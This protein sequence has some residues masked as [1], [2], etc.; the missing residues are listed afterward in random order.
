MQCE[1]CMVY[2]DDKYHASSK[3]ESSIMPVIKS[4]L[5]TDVP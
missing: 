5:S 1:Y 2:L 4:L 3:Y